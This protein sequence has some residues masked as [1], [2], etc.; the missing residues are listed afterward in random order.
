MAKRGN[1]PG[2]EA[3]VMPKFDMLFNTGDYKGAAE[4]AADSPKAFC[5]P[6]RP[7]LSS[8]AVPAAPGQNSPLLQYFG[9]CLQRGQLNASEA[10]ELA[11]LVLQQNKKQLLDTWMA[12]DKLECS[13]ALGDMLQ[14]VDPDMALRVYIKARANAKVVAALAGR[15]SS[16]RWASTAR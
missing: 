14:N 9:I 2:A 13:E 1:L 11:R 5:A 12:E 8:S 3:L 10:V 6:R 16:R 7:S 15:A 4:L